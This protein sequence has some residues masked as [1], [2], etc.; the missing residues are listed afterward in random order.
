MKS[1]DFVYPNFHN[2]TQ[3]DHVRRDIELFLHSFFKKWYQTIVLWK[4]KM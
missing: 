3:I 4:G 1:H 2:K